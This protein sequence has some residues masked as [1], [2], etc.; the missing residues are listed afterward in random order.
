MVGAC[1]VYE[2][3]SDVYRVLVSKPKGMRPL[4][5][6]RH[7]WE[8]NIW[9]DLKG[10]GCGGMDRIELALDRDRGGGNCECGNETS[11]FIKYREFL[12]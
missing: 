8:D 12:D 2:G 1:S 3:V 11:G 5:R 4:V 7:R 10:V 9:M 6:S